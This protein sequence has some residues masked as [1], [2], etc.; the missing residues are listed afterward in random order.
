[1]IKDLAP[2]AAAWTCFCLLKDEPFYPET[3]SPDTSLSFPEPL[4][5]GGHTPPSPMDSESCPSSLQVAQSVRASSSFSHSQVEYAL[6]GTPPPFHSC[7]PYVQ[8]SG[9]VC[10]STAAFARE[11]PS[12][13]NYSQDFICMLFQNFLWN[14]MCQSCRLILILSPRV[15]VEAPPPTP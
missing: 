10:R 1:M 15:P 11:L 8:V 6:P 13:L 7:A 3:S 9:P 2:A 12:S 4:S 5:P 14:L